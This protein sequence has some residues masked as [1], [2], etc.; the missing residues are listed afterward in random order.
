MQ[1]FGR[2]HELWSNENLPRIDSTGPYPAV[3]HANALPPTRYTMGNENPRHVVIVSVHFIGLHAPFAEDGFTE[4][5]WTTYRE[6][7]NVYLT[8]IIPLPGLP[9]IFQL[10][11]VHLRLSSMLLRFLYGLFPD[12]APFLAHIQPF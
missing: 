12:P 2:D 1:T 6:P 9:S 7:I 4:G 5:L 10:T 3:N 8:P 11:L